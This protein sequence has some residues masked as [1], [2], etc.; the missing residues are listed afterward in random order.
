MDSR[1]TEIF[2]RASEWVLTPLAKSRGGNPSNACVFV[3]AVYVRVR[4]GKHGLHGLEYM[5]NM[6][7]GLNS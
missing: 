2:G 6:I 3:W 7:Y 4:Q 1:K 5:V